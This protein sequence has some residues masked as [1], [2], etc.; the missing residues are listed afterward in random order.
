MK[1]LRITVGKKTYDVTVEV[2]G[3]EVSANPLPGPH[4]QAATRS[5]QASHEPAAASAAPQPAASHSA[6]AVVSPMAGLI[7]GILV[8]QG[9]EVTAGTVLIVLEA[10][11]MDNKIT[12]SSSGT[13]ASI[14]VQE[15][16]N[17]QEGQE[18]LAME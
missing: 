14:S 18:L 9:D 8:K 1:K 6:G 16:D 4:S 11:K 10:M 7:K 5:P 15:G 2:L 3:E 12:A 17:V 13:V